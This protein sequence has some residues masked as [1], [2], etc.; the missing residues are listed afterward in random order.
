M[1]MRPKPSRIISAVGSIAIILGGLGSMRTL[2]MMWELFFPHMSTRRTSL[3]EVINQGIF[4]CSLAYYKGRLLIG[5]VL[6]VLLIISGLGILNLRQWARKLMLGVSA[7]S[8]GLCV[9]YAVRNAALRVDS[10]IHV[11]LGMTFGIL[12]CGL[13][14]YALAVWVLTRPAVHEQF[15]KTATRRKDS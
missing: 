15:E 4:N 7:T 13:W 6:C 3:I 1:E 10:P 5:L 9:D 11:R 12:L 14:F 2:G 8:A